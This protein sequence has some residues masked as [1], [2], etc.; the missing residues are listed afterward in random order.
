M[1]VRYVQSCRLPTPFGVFDMHGFE[2]TDTGKEHLA[3]T[4]GALDSDAP[5][6]ARTHSECLTGDALYSMRCDCGYQLEEALRSI[7]REGRG[8]LMYLRQ[9]GR[10]IGLLNKIRAYRLQDEGA[11]TVEANEQLGFAADLR[12]Y[13]MCRDMLGHLGIRSLR[14]MTNN[15]RKVQA[16]EELGITIAERV[17]LHAGRN[18]HN[19]SYLAT[20]QSKLGHWLETH[21]DDD[22]DASL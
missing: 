8:I 2:E 22:P 12:D 7:A 16:L 13:S 4:L 15:P 6:L 9:E 21:Q 17:P 14:L 3:L 19:E 10:G 11:D 5:M 20:K 18:P 1:A